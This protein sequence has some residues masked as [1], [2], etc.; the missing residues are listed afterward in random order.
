M[1]KLRADDRRIEHAAGPP[2]EHL[3]LGAWAGRGAVRLIRADPHRGALLVERAGRGLDESDDITACEQIAAQ[4]AVLHRPADPRF[5]LLSDRL[6]A[7]AERLDRLPA[8]APLPHRLVAQA[9][10]RAREFAD[11]PDTDRVLLHGDLGYDHLLG[12]L[13]GRGPVVISPKPLAG[14]PGYELAPLLWERWP[15]ADAVRSIRSQL[16]SRFEAAVDAAGLDEDDARSWA[17]VRVVE[18]TLALLDDA[19]EVTRHVTIAKAIQR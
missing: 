4:L 13:D 1:L 9:A 8:S 2:L 7:L 15:R 14:H 16:V 19:E 6:A 10:G 5:P 3:A 18:R 12:S 17:L 11:D